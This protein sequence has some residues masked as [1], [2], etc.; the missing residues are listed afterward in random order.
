MADTANTSFFNDV[1]SF[2]DHAAQFTTVFIV[3][4]FLSA[5]RVAALRLSMPGG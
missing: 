3:F 5:K 4:A 1:C 2:F